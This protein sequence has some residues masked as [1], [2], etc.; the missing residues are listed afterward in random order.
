[1]FEGSQQAYLGHLERNAR[2][3]NNVAAAAVDDAWSWKHEA[4]R[5][6]AVEAALRVQVA[7]QQARISSLQGELNVSVATVQGREAQLE[8]MKVTHK[9]SPLLQ[10]AGVRFT[11]G[12]VKTKLSLVFEKAFDATLRRIGVTNPEAYRAS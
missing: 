7:E 5:L 2:R 1:M 8:E 4:D 9:D 12:D 3:A 6:A 11:D 10:D